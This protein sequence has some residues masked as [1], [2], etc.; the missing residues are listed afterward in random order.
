LVTQRVLELDE[1]RPQRLFEGRGLVAGSLAHSFARRGHPLVDA[2]G[3]RHRELLDLLPRVDRRSLDRLGLAGR[4]AAAL[5]GLRLL[6][7]VDRGLLLLPRPFELDGSLA[8]RL[9]ELLPFLCWAPVDPVGTDALDV[10]DLLLG[11]ALDHVV[12]QLAL[13]VELALELAGAPGH[14][15][16]E[17][18]ATP[19]THA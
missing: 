15:I 1:P 11:L 6:C 17:G 10:G 4:G 8:R 7:R 9:V 5:R 3:F 13:A 2:P 12:L 18:V 14:R 16:F 19:L